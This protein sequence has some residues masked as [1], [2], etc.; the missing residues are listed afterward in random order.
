MLHTCR[1]DGPVSRC[2]EVLQAGQGPTSLQT[3]RGG[4]LRQEPSDSAWWQ[5]GRPG[6]FPDGKTPRVPLLGESKAGPSLGQPGMK[7]SNPTWKE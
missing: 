7:F 2:S 1:K 3:W 5:G 4:R 6:G